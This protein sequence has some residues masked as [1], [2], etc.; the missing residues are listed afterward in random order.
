MQTFFAVLI[1]PSVSVFIS[2]KYLKY[3]LS[4]DTLQQLRLVRQ[5][6][7]RPVLQMK[8]IS[9]RS[10]KN[11][12]ASAFFQVFRAMGPVG[13]P[14]RILP[15]I[16]QTT[17]RSTIWLVCTSRSI[18]RK[19]IMIKC[20]LPF[21]FLRSSVKQATVFWNCLR[22]PMGYNKLHKERRVG[23]ATAAHIFLLSTRSTRDLHCGER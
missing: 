8:V 17:T 22:H 2:P 9:R 20:I 12:T 6:L 11:F 5:W 19:I 4:L 21:S 10:G 14:A 1:C 7:S 3:V 16:S 23:S 13:R 15:R 18:S